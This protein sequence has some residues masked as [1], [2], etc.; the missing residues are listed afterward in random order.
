MQAKTYNTNGKEFF[1][2]FRDECPSFLKEANTCEQTNELCTINSCEAFKR[3]YLDFVPICRIPGRMNCTVCMNGEE[4]KMGDCYKCKIA[5][6]YE[7][8]E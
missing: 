6:R 5:E 2:A 4:W 1:R 7:N 3:R 8:Q